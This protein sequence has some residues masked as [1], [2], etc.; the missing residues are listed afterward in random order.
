MELLQ[1]REEM[2]VVLARRVREERE[3]WERRMMEERDRLREE[4]DALLVKHREERDSV[5][6]KH[7][8]EM[9]SVLK[10]HQ[11]EMEEMRETKDLEIQEREVQWEKER[12]AWKEERDALLQQCRALEGRERD[13]VSV[14]TMTV[15]ED[16]QQ[17]QETAAASAVWKEKYE[18]LLKRMDTLHDDYQSLQRH[19]DALKAD[20]STLRSAQEMDK[21]DHSAVVEKLTQQLDTMRK[22]HRATLEAQLQSFSAIRPAAQLPLPG[23]DMTVVDPCTATA[24]GAVTVNGAAPAPAE[25]DTT[26]PLHLDVLRLQ[27]HHEKDLL[28]AQHQQELLHA[29]K[30]VRDEC[31]RAFQRA[32]DEMKTAQGALERRCRDRLVMDREALKRQFEDRLALEVE[33]VRREGGVR[34]SCREEDQE[35]GGRREGV[36]VEALKASLTALKAHHAE[37]MKQVERDLKEEHRRTLTLMK[38]QYLDTLKSMRDEVAQSKERRVREWEA[39]KTMLES[40]WQRR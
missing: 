34:G 22:Q 19:N 2:E 33:R 25:T 26:T 14:S 8:E 36:E 20:L 7:Q 12:L 29:R 13:V 35:D 10:K 11:E 15:N 21:A 23:V 24:T 17:E 27:W 5:L 30:T 3:G 9:D 1:I 40:E 16:V 37:E 32:L 6:K 28:L 4:G 39:K 31:T 38:E 18:S